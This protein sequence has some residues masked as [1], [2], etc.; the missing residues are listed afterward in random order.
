M[1]GIS[2]FIDFSKNSSLEIL[3]NMNTSLIH[4]GPDGGKEFFLANEQY[5]LGFA[6][7]RLAIIDLSEHG[8][9]PMHFNHLSILFNGEI[10]N[11]QEIK[12][13]LILMG[14]VFFSESDT[15][16]ILHA[17]YE[18]KEKCLDKFIG[19][20]SFV[21]YNKLENDLFI[22]RD[23][24][25]VKPFFYAIQ[26]GLFLF[27]SELKAFH[28]HTHFR[29]KINPNAVYSFLQYGSV[30]TPLCVF[31]NCFKLKPGHFIKVSLNQSL[32]KVTET[33]YWDVYDSYNKPQ[34]DL[35][36]QELITKTEKLLES[37]CNYRMVA[38]VPVGVF[39]SGGYD[40]AAV[41]TLLQKD[42]TEKLKTFTI[43]VPDIGLNEAPFAKQTAEL[44]GTDHTETECTVKEAIEIIEDLPHF[45]DEPFA[46]SSAIP[47]TLVSKIA[48]KSVTVAL[49]AD[50]GDEVFGGYN[51]YEMILKYHD[52]LKSTPA[53]AR[54]TISSLMNSISVKNI[55][56][57][58]NKY[59]IA[60]R[61]EKAKNILADFDEHNM[62]KNLSEL[63]TDSQIEKIGSLEYTK[64]TTYFDSKELKSLTPLRFSMSMDYQTYLL[65]DILQKVDRASMSAS[66][67]SR[68]PFLDHRLIE[69]AAQIPDEFKIRNGE[70]KW[71]LK[72][73]VHQYIPKEK[74]DRPK[75]GFAIPI[76]SWLSHE[77]VYQLEEYLSEK[78][79]KNT[80]LFN[81]SVVNDLK[82]QFLSGKKEFGV[83]IWYLFCYMQWHKH[84]MD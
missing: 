8:D 68:E 69:W 17:Y 75:S 28:Q 38:D 78:N 22:A 9:Q 74:M 33:K 3:K 60:H 15:E 52:K 10:Y 50:G 18:W 14:H 51:R 62:M 70:K 56:V 83:K 13:E 58:K 29:K 55:P 57:L 25:G 47:T 49:S 20:F 32:E 73:I 27:S 77:L 31:E 65:D 36:L 81:Y 63:F 39:L 45:Y 80:G 84:W 2:G 42:R 37:A 34:I 59:N 61:Y 4:R 26:N 1:C 40:S 72:E 16:M 79:I 46:D 41:T 35:P 76:E 30:P 11:F 54:K 43:S 23:R 53:F 66:L 21:I 67:E 5:Q 24:A 19:M 82:N 6:H 64:P 44:L 48:R 71:L 12:K 7:R